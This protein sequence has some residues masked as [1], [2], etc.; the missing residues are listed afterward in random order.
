MATED[1]A[2]NEVFVLVVGVSIT[3]SNFETGFT[4]LVVVDLVWFGLVWFGLV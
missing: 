3:G 2:L 4:Y 1:I